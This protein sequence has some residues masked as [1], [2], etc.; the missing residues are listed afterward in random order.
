MEAEQVEAMRREA[1]QIR[2]AG[3]ARGVS[4][5]VGGSLQ[6]AAGAAQM[7]AVQAAPPSAPSSGNPPASDTAPTASSAGATGMVLGGA[8][9]M[10]TSVGELLGAHHDGR[11]ADARTEQTAFGHRVDASERRAQALSEDSREALELQRGAFEHLE[12]VSESEANGAQAV[13]FRG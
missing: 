4:G 7:S 6:V 2:A 13:I 9:Q 1:D 10:S 12:N 11:A 8:G 3:M 5:I